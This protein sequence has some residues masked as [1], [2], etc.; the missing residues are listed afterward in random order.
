MRQSQLISIITPNYNGERFFKD[1]LISVFNQSYANWEMIIVDDCSTDNSFIEIKK[2][3]QKDLNSDPRYILL[4]NKNNVG[5]AETRNTALKRAKGRFICFLDID[6]YWSPNKLNSQINFMIENNLAFSYHDYSAFRNDF[7]DK[8]LY[9]VKAPKILTYH[10]YIKNTAIG[11]LTVM[12]DV[13]KTG[14]ILMPNI[15]SSHDMALWLNI[16]DQ[17]PFAKNVGLNLA[18]YRVVNTSNTSKK[19][20]AAKD[21]W[22]V[23]RKYRKHNGILSSFYFICYII[24]AIKKRLW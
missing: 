22:F 9:T 24:N 19:I 7:N 14:Q 3:I 1:C 23:I 21:V 15:R 13:T 4:K 16:L 20:E 6:D 18:K 5:P 2:F 11:C 12:V 10:G 8:I 17:I